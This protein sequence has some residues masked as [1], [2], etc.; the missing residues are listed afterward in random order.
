MKVTVSP[1]PVGKILKD[2]CW[3]CALQKRP[4]IGTSV[5]H[6][7]WLA[8]S[9]GRCSLSHGGSTTIGGL[10][11]SLQDIWVVQLH[12]HSKTDLDPL[13]LKEQSCLPT[14]NMY[15]VFN[16]FI[17]RNQF[18]SFYNRYILRT[19]CYSNY[20]CALIYVSTTFNL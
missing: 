7:Y 1:L 10:C 8:T 20:P 4:C 9:W 3:A 19:L 14:P 15:L 6:R 16:C 17:R 5:V 11:F 2:T 12:G 18:L 13:W